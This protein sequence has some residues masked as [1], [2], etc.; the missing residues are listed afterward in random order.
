MDNGHNIKDLNLLYIDAEKLINDIVLERIDKNILSIFDK[1]ID[2]L[3]EQWHG[4]D[5]FVQIN[6]LI[7][8]RNT[9]IDNR[10][11]IGNIGVFISILV[12]NYRDAQNANGVILPSFVQ[13]SY[14]KV[15]KIDKIDNNSQEVYMDGSIES[16]ITPLNTI[17]GSLEELNELVNKTMNSIFDNWIQNDENRNYALK[18][19]EKFSEFSVN[20]TD[21]INEFIK[22]INKSIDNYNSSKNNINSIPSLESMFASSSQIT[23]MQNSSEEKKILNSIDKNINSY[24][25]LSDKFNDVLVN[26]VKKDLI[27]KGIIE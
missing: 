23:N 25:K 24:K 8:A 17:I 18:M 13:L 27:S 15:K 12:K 4:K 6:K 22:C 7:D 11:I 21:I 9:F 2:N 16:T 3:I 19:F 20:V 26:E 1:T 10:D 14:S 5:A